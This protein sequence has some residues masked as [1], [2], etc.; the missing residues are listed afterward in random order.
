MQEE[1]LEFDRNEVCEMVPKPENV[2]VIGTKWIFRNKTDESG[3]IIRNMARLVAQGYSQ[4][5]GLDYEETFAPV[6]RLESIRLLIAMACDLKFKLYQ[7]DV[8]SAFLNDNIKEE[9]YISQPKGIEDPFHLKYVLKLKKALYG[10]KQAPRA[11]YERLYEF[12]INKEY[13]RGGADWIL[14]V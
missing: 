13:I 1:L 8:E 4:V 14:F 2:N 10:L 3:N 9:V 7:M 11:W 12:L 5:E 6:T